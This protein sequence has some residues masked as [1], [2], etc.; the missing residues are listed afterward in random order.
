MRKMLW[1]L[2]LL[3]SVF[4]T[5]AQVTTPAVRTNL[6]ITLD[7]KL[8]E[9]AWKEAPVISGF[10][11]MRP[12]FGRTEQFANRTEVY[13]LYDDDAVYFA[14]FNHESTR[15]SIATQLVGRDEVGVNDFTGIIFDTY[16]DKINGLGFFVSPLNEQFDIKY[17]IGGDGD[18]EDITWNT[19][20]H[21]ATQITDTGWSFEMRIPYAALRF[22]KDK[23]QDWNMHIMRRRVRSGQQFSWS[24]VDPTRFGLMNQAGTWKGIK[25]I[26][27][28]LRLSFSPYFSA[29][30]NKDAKDDNKWKSSFN[31]GMD[32]KYGITDGFTMDMTLIPDFGQVQSDN[33]VLNLTPF[34]VKFNENRT[35]FNEGTELFN[36][37]NLFYSRRIGGVP[38]H[39]SNDYNLNP[40]DRL[41]ENPAQTKLINATKLS[42][43]TRKKLGIGFFNALAK[44]QYATV[45]TADKERYKVQTSPLTNYNI[46]VVEQGL[47][48]N[49]R[50][51]LINTNV[52]RSGKDYDANVTS[53]DFDLYD[54][55]VDW[56]TWGQ[57]A[58]SR[59]RGLPGQN[60]SSTGNMYYM[61]VGRFKGRFNFYVMRRYVDD[62]YDQG[63]LGY[64]TNNNYVTH[65]SYLAYK[66]VKPHGIYN[67]IYLNF[68]AQYSQLYKPRRYQ[69]ARIN[70][71]GNSQ[72]KNLWVVG[73]NGDWR[74]GSND[75]YEA[76]IAGRVV[77]QP[78]SWMKGFFVNSNVAKK[79]RVEFEFYH[80]YSGRY[81][82]SGVQLFAGNSYRFNNKLTVSLTH[83][84]EFVNRNFGFAAIN[85]TGDSVFMS[86]RR[87]RTAENI[88]SAKYN[89]SNKTWLT[90]R[91]RHYWSKVRYSHFMHL[92]ADG[93]VEDVASISR[94]PDIN[95][96]LFNIDMNFTWQIAAGSFVNLTW[97][98]ASEMYNQLVT[99]RYHR[100]LGRAVEEP[101]FNSLSVKVIYFLDYLQLKKSR[102]PATA[103]H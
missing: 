11:E 77:K 93:R 2:L 92:L 83:S 91:M 23:I 96:N 61:A 67:N 81:N 97:K 89:F 85:Q 26:K 74:P 69:D 87:I 36:K 13:L 49:S 40:G 73:L 80:R 71:N 64:F 50:V 70:F 7:G 88:L 57:F 78:G 29:Y 5:K 75:F 63:D 98:S 47:K 46:L 38:L 32:V 103:A 9:A 34:E 68:N 18:G 76:R 59:L 95:V 60:P 35:F 20:Y 22:S 101:A 33:Q 66:W 15:D 30:L 21:T 8:D 42:G 100:N 27:P 55:N 53:V 16:R 28:P 52:W 14:G 25:D 54:N 90:F 1:L 43:R 72:L 4:E 39:Y 82:S 45:E 102:K 3:A 58:Q 37:G 17:A 24:P 51:T 56:N 79:Y 48:N 10:T 41:I 84:L 86:L 62:K 6:P 12:H 44:A 31:G 94:N 19:V 65:S 99:E